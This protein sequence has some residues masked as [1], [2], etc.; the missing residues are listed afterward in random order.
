MRKA[1]VGW[2]FTR[3]YGNQDAV[4]CQHTPRT[5]SGVLLANLIAQGC[6]WVILT[7]FLTIVKDGEKGSAF[8]KALGDCNLHYL[9]SLYAQYTWCNGLLGEATVKRKTL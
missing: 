8:K 6:V 2:C 7:R 3:F 9:G 5:C 4:L 1:L